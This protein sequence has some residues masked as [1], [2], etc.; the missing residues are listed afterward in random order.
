[1]EAESQT[2]IKAYEG[3]IHGLESRKAELKERI[4]RS[5]QN[6][7]A[8]DTAFRT[9]MTFLANPYKIG[10]CGTFEQKRRVLKLAFADR[11]KYL[12]NSVFRTALTSSPFT[13]LSSVGGEGEEMVRL[14][15]SQSCR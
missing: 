5:G 8:F 15:A 3:R 10:V 13:L 12:R 4:A 7:K 11:L 2:L 9:A 1:M 14:Q 6:P